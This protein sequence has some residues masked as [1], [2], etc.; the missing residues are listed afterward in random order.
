[1]IQNCRNAE[2][3]TLRFSSR[4][5]PQPPHS[6]DFLAEFYPACVCNRLGD[7]Y[8]ILSLTN[9]DARTKFEPMIAQTKLTVP[10]TFPPFSLSRLLKTVFNPSAGERVAILID[11]DDPHEIKNFG[12]LE[13]SRSDDSAARV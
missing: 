7:V 13:E 2:H 9:S 10:E 3:T 6:F 11:L 8:Q 5:T 4:S 12:F 1:M